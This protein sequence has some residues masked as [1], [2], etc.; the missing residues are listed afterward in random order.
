MGDRSGGVLV[1]WCVEFL[2]LSLADGKE[3]WVASPVR[4]AFG[5]SRSRARVLDLFAVS[6]LE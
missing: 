5:R 3:A 1:C 4:H 6:P 2:E